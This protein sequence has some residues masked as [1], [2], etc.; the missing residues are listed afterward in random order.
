MRDLTILYNDLTEIFD[1]DSRE[2]RKN[3][4]SKNGTVN[5]I[6]IRACTERAKSLRGRLE[7]VIPTDANTRG[8]V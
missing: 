2:L 3:E 6:N 1:Q 4:D 7:A 5:P 8:T